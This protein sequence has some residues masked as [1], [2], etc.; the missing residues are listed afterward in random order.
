MLLTDYY[1][2]VMFDI[3]GEDVDSCK[4]ETDEGF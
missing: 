1:T 2:F 3:G 4:E